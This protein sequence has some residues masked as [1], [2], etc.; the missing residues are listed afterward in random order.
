[1]P[2]DLKRY[3]ANWRDL[4]RE[5][6]IL[7]AGGRCEFARADL[8]PCSAVDGRPH[9]VTGSLVVLTVAHLWR[10]P[11]AAH[12]AAG[13]K[14]DNPAHL[15]ALCQRCH[16]GYDRSEHV[17]KRAASRRAARATGDLFA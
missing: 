4:S 2:M 5:I 16:L 1:M 9:P 12:H 8:P 17:R 7:R 3:P 15:A 14:C 11:C 13:I 6:R 10:G